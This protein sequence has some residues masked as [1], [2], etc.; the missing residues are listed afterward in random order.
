[1]RT[2]GD[3]EIGVHLPFSSGHPTNYLENMRQESRR[4]S[5]DAHSG[6]I[7]LNTNLSPPKRFLTAISWFHWKLRIHLPAL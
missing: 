3:L 1:M 5:A 6:R 2:D 7:A 4:H